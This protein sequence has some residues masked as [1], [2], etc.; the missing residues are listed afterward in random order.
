MHSE[1]CDLTKMLWKDTGFGI[2]GNINIIQESNN[3][4]WNE[5]LCQSSG[6]W[7]HTP[8]VSFWGKQYEE[9]VPRVCIVFNYVAGPPD[10][11]AG[12]NVL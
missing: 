2:S 8:V 6:L 5:T 11:P 9:S 3:G 4:L 10:D 7:V 1:L 12:V